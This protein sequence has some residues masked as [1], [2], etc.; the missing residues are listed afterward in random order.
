MNLSAHSNA[1]SEAS[2]E[3]VA[4]ATHASAG[5]V[6]AMYTASADG[7]DGIKV[8]RPILEQKAYSLPL[9]GPAAA[10]DAA[11]Y[12]EHSRAAQFAHLSPT[13]I[14]IVTPS[15]SRL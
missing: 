14:A 12:F 9:P 13:R 11:V 7:A 3:S 2:P 1:V 8:V 15:P 6:A 5:G 4:V 10:V